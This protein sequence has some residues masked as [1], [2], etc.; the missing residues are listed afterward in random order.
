MTPTGLSFT[1]MSL[2]QQQ[3]YIALAL[4]FDEEPLQSLDELD[5]GVLRVDYVPPGWFEW[6]VPG[7]NWF[8]FAVPVEPGREGRR[9]MAPV[10]R[11]QTRKAALAA[12]RRRYQEAGAAMLREAQRLEPH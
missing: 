9:A 5:G 10:V 7:P 4:E 1:R 3:R 2:A 6:A 8:R 12:A 11:E